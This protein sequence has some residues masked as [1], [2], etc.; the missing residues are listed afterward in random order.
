MK[1]KTLLA[2]CV[3]CTTTAF[4]HAATA[5]FNGV[6]YKYEVVNGEAQ[7]VNHSGLGYYSCIDSTTTGSLLLPSVLNG[8][9]VTSIGPGAFHGCENLTSIII[10]EGIK[11]IDSGAFGYCH[12]LETVSLP[13]SLSGFPAKEG[14]RGDEFKGCTNAVFLFHGPFL[15]DFIYSEE[16]M[17]QSFRCRI[18]Y[19]DGWKSA[20]GEQHFQNKFLGFIPEVEVLS[21]SIR[22]DDPTILDVVYRVSS[23]DPTV[24]IRALAFQDGER[25]FWKVVRPET[26][27]DGTATNIGDNVAANVEHTLSWKVSAD[28]DIDLATAKFEI[29][30]SEQGQLPLDWMKV[31]G[32]NGW[33]DIEFSTNTQTDNDV[34]NAMFWYYAAAENDL[35]I[36]DGYLKTVDGSTLVNR[37]RIGDKFNC[38]SYIIGKMGLE[39]FSGLPY[40]YAISALRM[41]LPTLESFNTVGM[42]DGN[43]TNLAY[44]G[45]KAYCVI[46]VSG[47]TAA[48]SYPV[49]YLDSFPIAGWGDEYKTTKI[50]LRR[51][52]LGDVK[53]GDKKPVTLTQPFY[54]G[55]F[56]ITQKQYQLVTGSDPSAYKGDKR[57][58]EKVSWNDIR[59]DSSTYNWPNVT[60]VDSSS[61]IG[62]LQAK[63]GLDFDLP[64]ESQWEYACRAGTTSSYN[65]GG[66]NENDLKTLGRYSDNRNDGR[67]G[68]SEH[69]A[70]GSYAPNAWDLYDM[71]GNVIEWC[72]DWSGSSNSD[73]AT[74]W[75]GPSSGSQRVSRG[76]N[77]D[78]GSSYC[79]HSN[80][81]VAFAPST[82]L[83]SFGFRLSRTLSE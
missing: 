74:D 45:D 1:T 51:I 66:S 13:E 65:N 81:G 76:G 83:G 31:P 33:P 3:V 42:L 59:G 75:P 71:H 7:L 44:V 4:A 55:V 17:G 72:L 9:S 37:D 15:Q 22:T 23:D 21:S 24:N 68:Y 73:P 43:I 16:L 67:G 48:T 63:T 40:H 29:L 11:T 61:F 41:S 49:T 10:P 53:M 28:W 8:C 69:T 54:I 47:G 46:D 70:V 56:E 18:K 32:V 80:R 25:S 6:Q 20:L 34:L 60:T 78:S 52:E 35:V 19:K 57:P 30:A 14:G 38:I 62:V 50:L 77:W 36:E 79:R 64:T 58:V 27:V 5:Y 39:R 82:K 2:I 26:F 12:N